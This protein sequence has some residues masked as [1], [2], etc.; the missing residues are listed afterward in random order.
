MMRYTLAMA[1]D[2]VLLVLDLAGTFAFA[3]NGAL[4]AV[5]YRAS[6]H[7]RCHHPRHHYCD[8][9]GH[10]SRRPARCAAVAW[11]IAGRVA[12]DDDPFFAPLRRYRAQTPRWDV[13]DLTQTAAGGRAT[14]MRWSADSHAASLAHGTARCQ[15]RPKRW[16]VPAT[17]WR[18]GR[19]PTSW[20]RTALTVDSRVAIMNMGGGQNRDAHTRAQQAEQASGFCRCDIRGG[21]RSEG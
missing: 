11:Q 18:A 7:R 20:H 10:H 17:W 21:H 13:A 5:R 2:P 14:A 19:K 8:G 6:G 3:L 16:T 15:Q 9:W 1:A 12:G 4:A